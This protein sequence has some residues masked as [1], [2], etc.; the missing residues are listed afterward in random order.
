LAAIAAGSAPDTAISE[1]SRDR[2]P[3]TTTVQ[4]IRRN[5]A[6]CREQASAR[7]IEMA[8]FLGQIGGRGLMP[9]ACGR[10]VI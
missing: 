9:A 3:N 6:E 8:A 4:K 5:D 7:Q 2:S 10:P 1:P